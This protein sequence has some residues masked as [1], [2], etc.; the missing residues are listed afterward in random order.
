MQAHARNTHKPS[1]KADPEVGGVVPD[2]MHKKRVLLDSFLSMGFE[3]QILSVTT[4][5]LLSGLDKCMGK[6]RL[7][8]VCVAWASYS[9]LTLEA[10]EN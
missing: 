9:K 10:C 8:Y 6:V 4:L 2:S 5:T 3:H 7:V 1:F